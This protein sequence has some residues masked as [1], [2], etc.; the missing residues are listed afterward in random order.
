MGVGSGL[1]MYDVAVK[2]SCSPSHLL[3]SSCYAHTRAAVGVE[4]RLGE[5]FD[6]YRSEARVCV[7]STDLSDSH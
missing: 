5:W 6:S 2:R 1:Y 3:M 4:G 7:V